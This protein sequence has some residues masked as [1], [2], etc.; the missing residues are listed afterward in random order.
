LIASVVLLITL[1]ALQPSPQETALS[2]LSAAEKV[3]DE[4]IEASE[5]P[6][7]LEEVRKFLTSV[8]F[9]AEAR[10]ELRKAL[11]AVDEAKTVLQSDQARLG[12][13]TA[14]VKAQITHAKSNL[15]ALTATERIRGVK[16]QIL[17]LVWPVVVVALILYLVNAESFRRLLTDLGA[18]VSNIKVPGGLEIAF[19]S[20]AVKKTQEEVMR[21]YRNQ[22]IATYDAAAIQYQISDTVNRIVTD[23]I[24]PFFERQTNLN[25]PDFRCTIHVR[26][27]LFQD[28]LYQ[29]IDYLPR[30][31]ANRSGG[32]GRVW[33][34]RYGMMGRYWRLERNYA[35][36][37]V[38]KEEVQLIQ[39]WGMTKAEAETASGR[40][41]L[42]CYLV[43]A[44][45][46]SPLAVFYLD[47]EPA[48]AFGDKTQME[49][50][51][52]VVGDAVKEFELDRALEKVWHQVQ[53]SAPLIENPC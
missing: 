36:D 33:S 31:R 4:Q 10:A 32:R 40:Q 23:R 9:P 41:T 19:N 5:V 7:S 2:A 15:T 46:Q 22:V 29:L 35:Q 1:I 16:D 52:K 18:A 14:Q 51:L 12:A 25:K 13:A 21:G 49:D 45:N 30:K 8:E 37:S 6:A 43:R 48:S 24:E 44:K 28:S 39:D 26:D 53:S 17:I 34:V 11:A 20:T 42:F 27:I 3:L 50:L 47:A 38:P